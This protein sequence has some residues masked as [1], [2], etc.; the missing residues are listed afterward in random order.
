MT[1]FQSTMMVGLRAIAYV[2]LG[3][4]ALA[5]G[6]PALIADPV[7]GPLFFLGLPILF[8]GLA[9]YLWT[10]WAFVSVGHGTP[11]PLDPPRTLVV[12]GLYRVVRNPMALGFCLLFVG[13]AVAFDALQILAYAAVVFSVIHLFI[14][15]IEEPGLKR[16]F[17][18]SYEAYCQSVPR[19]IPRLSALRRSSRDARRPDPSGHPDGPR[20]G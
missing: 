3:F 19:W 13:E 12:H 5:A 15:F 11:L 10:V 20:T 9:L 17:G 7:P 14:V 18:A 4:G 1:L 16:R 8:A 6:I 2:A